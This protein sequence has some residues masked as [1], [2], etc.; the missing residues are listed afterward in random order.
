MRSEFVSL[1]AMTR[2]SFVV[3][4]GPVAPGMVKVAEVA[5]AGA[6]VVVVVVVEG[7]GDVCPKGA[8][9]SSVGREPGASVGA[10]VVVRR[11]EKRSPTSC[12]RFSALPLRTWY[13]KNFEPPLV[14]PMLSM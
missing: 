3:P 1:S 4:P 14:A 2:T 6:G 7:V 8:L 12:A 5:P 11:E 10:V 13:T 9:R